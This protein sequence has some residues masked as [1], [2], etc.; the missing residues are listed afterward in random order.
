M[1]KKG[2]LKAFFGTEK[3][4]LKL[5]EKYEENIVFFNDLLENGRRE[6]VEFVI[7]IKMYNYA[8]SLEKEGYYTK[9]FSVANEIERDLKRLRGLSEWYD[10]YSEGAMFLKGL[11]LGRLKKYRESNKYFKQL[12]EKK[13]T[14][15]NFVNWY[16]SNK[17]NQI[18][19][20]FSFI[21]IP[22]VSL[23]V[24]SV[25]LSIVNISTIKIPTIVERFLLAIWVLAWIVPYIWGRIIEK[26]KIK[27]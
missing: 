9:A 21:F 24:I 25:V 20:I 18:K 3:E 12:V 6:D 10:M 15:D 23:F 11:C 4:S 19:K 7:P 22:A 1:T 13:T 26:Q 8:F 16:K 5:I 17:K 14:N 27:K 2:K